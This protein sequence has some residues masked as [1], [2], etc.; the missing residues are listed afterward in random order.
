[1]KLLLRMNERMIFKLIHWLVCSPNW[2]FSVIKAQLSFIKTE[3]GMKHYLKMYFTA[4]LNPLG[5]TVS[6]LYMSMI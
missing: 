5:V 6:S 2:I 1:M 3:S 4:Q